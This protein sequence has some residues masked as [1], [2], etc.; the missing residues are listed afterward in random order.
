MRSN[1]RWLVG[2]RWCASLFLLNTTHWR[3]AINRIFYFSVL[4]VSDLA[5]ICIFSV[6]NVW[7]LMGIGAGMNRV[8]S[9]IANGNTCSRKCASD[10]CY[11]GRSSCKCAL[12]EDPI[13][14]NIVA[15]HLQASY[16]GQHVLEPRST[17]EVVKS[18]THIFR[19]LKAA[20]PVI[21]QNCDRQKEN[22][23]R[24]TVTT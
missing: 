7:F 11:R 21:D 23:S 9:R 6:D 12:G 4:P 17:I 15:E 8:R 1:R 18:T 20:Q 5:L 16:G 2:V 13:S 24:K 3:M 14:A 10:G 19:L 22:W